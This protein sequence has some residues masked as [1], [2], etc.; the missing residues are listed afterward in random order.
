MILE[1]QIKSNE[2][3]VLTLQEIFRRESLMKFE[4]IMQFNSRTFPFRPTHRTKRG[5]EGESSVRIMS[6]SQYKG[7]K[8]IST[9]PLNCNGAKLTVF[10]R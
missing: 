10:I 3:S 2:F 8:S 1:S 6:R 4:M 9:K 5:G 7:V